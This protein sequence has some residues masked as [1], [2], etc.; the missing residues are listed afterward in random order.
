MRDVFQEITDKITAQLE[1]GVRPWAKPWKDGVAPLALELP[2]NIAGRPYRGGNVPMLWA[3]AEEAGYRSPCWLTFN[4]AHERGGHVRKGERGALVF[5]W[6]W[7]EVEDPTTGERRRRAFARAYTVFNLDQVEGVDVPTVQ[8]RELPEFQRIEAADALMAA[9]GA[10]IEY[11]GD[12]ACFVP[13]RDLVRLPHPAA[14]K[15]PDA[16][17]STA[18]HELGHWTGHADRLAREFGKRFGDEAYAFEELVA[19]LTAAFV[20]ASQGF[21]SVVREDHASYIDHWLKVLKHDNRAFTAAAGK[22][23][24]A[25]DFILGAG[26]AEAEE[27]HEMPALAA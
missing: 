19:E 26:A 10:R 17:Y 3:L 25:A 24:Q 8:P 27:P 22:A 4:Q 18:F 15:A 9:T 14:F 6:K 5:F 7:Q 16:F 23:Q 13:S 1:A 21:A 12:V 2:H 20:C 11:G